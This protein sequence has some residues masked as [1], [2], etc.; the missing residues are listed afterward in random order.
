MFFA[1]S[2]LHPHSQKASFLSEIPAGGA[3]RW[4]AQTKPNSGTVVFAKCRARRSCWW[5]NPARAISSGWRHKSDPPAADIWNSFYLK[6]E[7][8]AFST[9]RQDHA[10][11]LMGAGLPWYHILCPGIQVHS[12]A[13]NTCGLTAPVTNYQAFSL[14]SSQKAAKPLP[15]S[16]SPALFL[17]KNLTSLWFKR[18]NVKIHPTDLP[19]IPQ[20]VSYW[21]PSD[22][23]KE[24]HAVICK[25]LEKQWYFQSCISL[26][27]LW[28][29][30]F[31]LARSP[32][33][34]R[35]RQSMARRG[36]ATCGRA[37]STP[38]PRS[39]DTNELSGH[40]RPEELQKDK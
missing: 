39:S 25:C 14:P 23:E 32:T 34:F 21:F 8:A 9:R 6:T 4:M 26:G 37:H 2:H 10:V 29:P 35:P 11:A 12:F 1:L 40:F 31:P 20:P 18:K 3:A 7:H 17:V 5:G 36:K 33:K 16:L 38:G 19:N 13:A 27:W 30:L 28:S 24:L 15:D 22:Q